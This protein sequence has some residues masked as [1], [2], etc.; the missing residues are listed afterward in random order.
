MTAEVRPAPG[1]P[2]T[3]L[4]A[5]LPALVVGLLL[6]LAVGRFAC[7]GGL[8]TADPA[9]SVP[10]GTMWSCSMCPQVMLPAFGDCPVCGM[11]LIPLLDEAGDGLHPSELRVS[12][13]AAAL[14][15]IVTGRVERRAVTRDVR[16]VGR[17]ALDP[18]RV[19]RLVAWGDTTIER[20]FVD[21]VGAPVEEDDP[22]AQITSPD[23]VAD[24][25]ALLDAVRRQADTPPGASKS[26][27][28]SRA[29][30]VAAA[31]E[32]LRLWG[33]TKD[34]VNE[35]VFD[36]A[37]MDPVTLYA[38]RDGVV[39]RRDGAPGVPLE[40]GDHLLTYADL[41]R[42]WIELD[43]YE[44]DLAWLRYGQELRFETPAW[45]GE[46]FE[47]RTNFIDPAID[48]RTRTVT[49]R[50]TVDNVGHRLKPD[51]FVRAT[52]R[53]PVSA[54][55]LL[56]DPQLADLFICPV[57]P[58]VVSKTEIRCTVCR[59]D[60]VP[61]WELGMRSAA[62][63]E[64]PLVVPETA[65]LITG[66]R[67][68]VFV[69]REDPE[70]EGPVFEP[71][72]V[73]LGPRAAGY[74][75]VNSG[76][77]PGEEIVVHGAFKLDSEL[78]IRGRPSMMSDD[79]RAA[80]EP[81]TRADMLELL[82]RVIDPLARVGADLADGNVW[83][84]RSTAK[85]LVAALDSVKVRD[86]GLEEPLRTEWFTAV[87]VIRATASRLTA[88]YDLEDLRRAYRIAS[89]NAIRLLETHGWS[90]DG[91]APVVYR[92]PEAFD[93]QGAQWLTRGDAVLNPY[94]GPDPERLHC[95]ALR[96]RLER[97]P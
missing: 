60:T 23:L 39:L 71:R 92:C 94:L 52:V 37:P 70:H 61:S 68:V 88:S 59:R 66:K 1:A 8:A 45:P 89:D 9:S 54:S 15:G 63:G 57:H 29:A 11:D 64:E 56:V 12:E 90:G 93:R 49:L 77:R 47:G 86:E 97:V 21:A 95:G 38:A 13:N 82:G 48:P 36:K 32:R 2:R 75:L 14:A 41:D 22:L 81:G 74:Y 20:L 55:G 25:V 44:T 28:E 10:P 43:A 42:V 30:E 65:P 67:A 26:E 31:R 76:L 17:V 19:V 58:E 62:P 7:G 69:K 5:R 79:E 24:Q 34:Q 16:M 6:G 35:V 72:E 18:T 50:A 80:P 53:S 33:L 91:E 40:E 27:R 51:M 96:A 73:S 3:T 85:E 83:A 4:A 46:V 84:T 87:G 78:Q